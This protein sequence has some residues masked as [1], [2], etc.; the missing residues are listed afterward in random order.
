VIFSNVSSSQMD[1]K[2][3]TPSKPKGNPK[4]KVKTNQMNCDSPFKLLPNIS[5]PPSRFTKIL[6]PFEPHL[7]DR[8]HLPTFSPSVF[9]QVSTPKTTEKFKWTIDDISSL[10]P[11]DIDEATISQH[12][13]EHDPTMES[14]V[15]EKINKFFNEKSIA[16]S[17]FTEQINQKRLI[18]SPTST[19]KPQQADSSAQTMLT[20][21]PILP[22]H[23]EDALAPYFNYNCDQQNSGADQD[24]SLYRQLFDFDDHEHS[25]PVSSPA[26]STGLSP[27]QFSSEFNSPKRKLESSL[28]MPELRDCTLSPIGRSPTGRVALARSAC[29]LSFSNSKYMSIDASMVVPDVNKSLSCTNLESNN[30]FQP[31]EAPPSEASVNWDMEYKQVSIL[32]RSPISSPEMIDSSNSNTPHSK[33]FTSQRKRLSDSFKD[34]QFEK[35]VEMEDQEQEVFPKRS[36]NRLGKND[37][38]DAGYHTGGATICESSVHMFA[39]T[40]TKNKH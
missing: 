38:T 12:V 19:P 1:L 23:V 32:S 35:D 10:K 8:L 2:N 30:S 24:S 31:V 37:L 14:L 29:R 25:S 27:L 20:L 16:P 7:I 39:S 18:T 13:S 4:N 33:I 17:P 22:K 36:K 34:E 3:E 6:N 5:T 15:Q 26:I 28:E 21:P 9:A 11:A 40:P